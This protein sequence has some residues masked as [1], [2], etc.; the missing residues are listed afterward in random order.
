VYLLVVIVTAR[1]S[2]TI[3]ALARRFG[4]MERRVAERARLQAELARGAQ[5]ASVGALAAGVA[6]EIN[7]PLTTILGYA[8]LLLEDKPEGHAD[9]EALALVA[10]EARRVQGIVRTLLDHAR[11]ETGPARREPLEVNV[12]CE[13]T[14]AL[15]APTLKKR[16][17]TLALDLGDAAALPRPAGDPRRLEQVFVNLGQNAAQAM[18]AG[19]S[20]TIRT[21]AAARGGV[22][23]EFQDTGPGIPP[24]VLGQ[25][26]EPFFTTKGPGVGTGLGLAISHQIALDHG[27][28][29]EVESE[30]G[31]GSTFRV[32]LGESE[33]AEHV[34]EAEEAEA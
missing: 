28:R 1:L 11:V 8:N 27:G 19:G 4:E 6:H 17:V 23:V 22:A 25:I 20:L 34:E 10:D 29:I 24:E 2:G 26:F 5:L 12:L 33:P 32:I 13:R 15:L 30:V 14:A 9:R 31:R 16:R 7:N 18:E 3:G 21:R